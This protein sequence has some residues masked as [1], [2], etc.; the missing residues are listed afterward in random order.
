MFYV[1]DNNFKPQKSQDP[2]PNA[3]LEL[4]HFPLQHN[5]VCKSLVCS[6]RGGDDNDDDNDDNEL[7][8][9]LYLLNNMTHNFCLWIIVNFRDKFPQ[10]LQDMC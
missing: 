2:S 7:H 8:G 1:I 9:M 4:I 6:Q 3:S 10:T 5:S